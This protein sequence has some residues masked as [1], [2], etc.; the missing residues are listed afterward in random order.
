V[1]QKRQALQAHRTQMGEGLFFMRLPPD[2]F[3]EAFGRETFQRVRGP[4]GLPERD[5]FE[6]L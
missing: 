3:A 5:L 6:G 4:G 2:L 1:A